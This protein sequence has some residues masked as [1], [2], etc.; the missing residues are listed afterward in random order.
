MLGKTLPRKMTKGDR[1]FNGQPL[2]INEGWVTN[3]KYAIFIEELKESKQ[4][5]DILNAEAVI[6]SNCVGMPNINKVIPSLEVLQNVTD[7]KLCAINEFAALLRVLKLENGGLITV[8]NDMFNVLSS[9]DYEIRCKG[10]SEPLCF[11]R[12][13]SNVAVL[14]PMRFDAAKLIQDL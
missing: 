1:E 11:L 4:K 9:G 3:G 6:R 2:A 5:K 12:N 14:M 10:V 13:G 7:T 8:D